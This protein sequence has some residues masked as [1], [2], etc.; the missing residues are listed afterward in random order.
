MGIL[1][2]N[3]NFLD[4]F[5]TYLLLAFSDNFIN[6]GTGENKLMLS[7]YSQFEKKIKHV[8]FPVDLK[9]WKN[10]NLSKEYIIFVGND[11]RD[12]EF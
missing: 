1:D 12:F 7:K 8:P 10:I 6:L 4:K 3:I 11:N 5:I 9:F 2:K